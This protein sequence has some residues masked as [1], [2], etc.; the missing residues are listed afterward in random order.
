M[1]IILKIRPLKK[2]FWYTLND[3]TF[4]TIENENRIRS[5]N[6]D[7]CFTFLLMIKIKIRKNKNNLTKINC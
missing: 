6:V 4:S 5:E 3:E 2:L 7:G 1:K